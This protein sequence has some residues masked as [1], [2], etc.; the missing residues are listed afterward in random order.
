VTSFAYLDPDG[1]WSF[2]EDFPCVLRH[3]EAIATTGGQ[4]EVETSETWPSHPWTITDPSV[5]TYQDCPRCGARR[6]RVPTALHPKP[7]QPS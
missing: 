3:V 6:I 5:P 4:A 7:L 2:R 1:T